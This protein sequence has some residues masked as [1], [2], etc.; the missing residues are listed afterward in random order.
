L[1][2]DRLWPWMHRTSQLIPSMGGSL[3]RG[4]GQARGGIWRSRSPCLASGIILFVHV[5]HPHAAI[6]LV[7]GWT[8]FGAASVALLVNGW[9]VRQKRQAG[10]VPVARRTRPDETNFRNVGRWEPAN[11]TDNDRARHRSTPD[12]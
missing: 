9:F 10:F 1:T 2:R 3:R 4:H 12:P 7:L 8:M 6:W 5:S 11:R